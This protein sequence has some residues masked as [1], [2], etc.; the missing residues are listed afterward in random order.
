MTNLRFSLFIHCQWLTYKLSNTDI[1]SI[2][3]LCI[4]YATFTQAGNLWQ[5]IFVVDASGSM[6]LNRM[7]NAKGAALQLL[8]ESYTSRDQVSLKI[9]HNTM[10]KLHIYVMHSHA[11]SHAHSPECKLISGEN[12]NLQHCGSSC[13]NNCISSEI[14]GVKSKVFF[15]PFYIRYQSFLSVEISQK[16]SCLHRGQ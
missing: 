16:F 2:E 8:A 14:M 4:F 9:K 6:A 13:I 5:V 7:Q 11:H 10:L 15:P 12:L 1:A 3:C